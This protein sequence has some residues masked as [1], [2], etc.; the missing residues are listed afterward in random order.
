VATPSNDGRANGNVLTRAWWLHPL[1]L[2]AF[3]VL[4]LFASNIGEQVGIEPLGPPLGAAVLVSAAGLLVGLAI[5]RIAGF[6]PA[7]A[8][9]VLSLVIAL[10]FSYGH[11]WAAVG[12]ALVLHRYLLA[13]WALVAILGV[14]AVAF[15]TRRQI[16]AA[17]AFLNVVGLA[18]VAVNVLPIARLGLGSE[19]TASAAAPTSSETDG[20]AEPARPDIWYLVFD[21]YA[22]ADGLTATYGFD[23]RPFVAELERRG[24]DVVEHATANYLKTALSLDSTLNMDYLD[25]E[26]LGRAAPTP[27]D[28]SP[29]YRELQ[30][31]TAVE[32][33]LHDRGYEYVHLGLRRGAT[34]TNSAADRVYLYG[35]QSEF[36]AVLENTTL[37]V[38]LE[39][40]MSDEPTGLA[41]LYGHQSLYQLG[42]LDQLAR[43]DGPRPR[44][45]FAHIL[46]PHPPYV[47]NEDGSWV[48]DTQRR[49][50]SADE[51]YLEQLRFVNARIL[52]L[53]DSI[54]ARP[55]AKRPILLIQAD[56]GPF[57]DRYER[58]EEGFRWADA[59][60]EELLRKFSILAAYRMP[61]NV[62]GALELG[63]RMTPVNSFRA[64]FNATF[65]AGLDLLDDRNLVFVDQRHLYEMVDVTDRV[66]ALP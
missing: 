24:F 46:L 12:A 65:D 45:V 20:D 22:G 5:A 30:G 63:D 32:R 31:S 9:L 55:E 16:G 18:L 41:G 1:L 54:D 26:A 2:S 11:V 60:D 64:I 62:P 61:P 6:S 47:F 35:D 34:Y 13:A 10:F 36:A 44:F 56:E 17:T 8:T 59:T 51:Q 3:P 19:P 7:R 53:V 43:S 21:R 52:D 15:A 29:V 40:V 39:H 33:F 25:A 42:V 49:E 28:W 27:D 38:A 4:F 14:C 66:R 50:R 37:L 23:N 58:D 57:P 48:T